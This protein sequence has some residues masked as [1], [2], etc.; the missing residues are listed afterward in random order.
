MKIEKVE[1]H[2]TC[3]LQQN[4]LGSCPGG[5]LLLIFLEA[6]ETLIS[7]SQSMLLVGKEGAYSSALAYTTTVSSFQLLSLATGAYPGFC[8]IV[9]SSLC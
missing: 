4:L 7:S 6:L 1:K 2:G 5:A 3:E 8:S 9:Y